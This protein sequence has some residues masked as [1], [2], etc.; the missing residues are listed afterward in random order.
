MS[1]EPG[2]LRAAVERLMEAQRE[3]LEVTNRALDAEG[4][5]EYPGA[6]ER[7]EGALVDVRDILEGALE[8]ARDTLGG[9]A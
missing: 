1:G 3:A 9:E 4:E 6:G 8:D 2:P 5:E 7:L